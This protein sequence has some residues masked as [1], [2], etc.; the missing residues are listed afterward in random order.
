MS[1]LNWGRTYQ[2]SIDHL[3]CSQAIFWMAL[4]W[5]NV[6]Q[7][8][9]SDHSLVNISCKS[10]SHVSDSLNI[11]WLKWA[12]CRSGCHY[13]SQWYDLGHWHRPAGRARGEGKV[14]AITLGRHSQ[15]SKCNQSS[16]QAAILYHLCTSRQCCQG[17]NEPLSN[18]EVGAIKHCQGQTLSDIHLSGLFTT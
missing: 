11:F 9:H 1:E 14:G 15:G 6:W 18:K 8:T 10:G 12:S 7:S 3:Q 5:E 17:K 16:G 4:L 2:C 13:G